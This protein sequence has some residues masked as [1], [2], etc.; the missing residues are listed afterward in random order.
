MPAGALQAVVYD[1]DGTLIDSR[2]DLAD[3][4]NAMLARLGLPQRDAPI[5]HGFIGEGAERVIRR[6]PGPT[7]EGRHSEGGAGSAAPWVQPTKGATPRRRRSG[8][9]STAS[10]CWRKRASIR[11]PP[12]CCGTHP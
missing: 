8:A 10:A 3:S 5:L 11:A 6:S 12:S 7:H 9:K 4:V 1:L 2:H